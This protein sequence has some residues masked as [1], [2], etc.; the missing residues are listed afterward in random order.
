MADWRNHRQNRRGSI[1]INV[2]ELTD[3][4]EEDPKVLE[5]YFKEVVLPLSVVPIEE[6]E[7]SEEDEE[8]RGSDE[9]SRVSEV[10]MTRHRLYG[11]LYV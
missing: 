1:S 4:G 7:E 3:E 6:E 9:G 5:E 2:H 8:S 10:M 11:K